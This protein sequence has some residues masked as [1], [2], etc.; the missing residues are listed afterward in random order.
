[1][2][3]SVVENR[4]PFLVYAGGYVAHVRRGR[5]QPYQLQ[6]NETPICGNLPN[7]RKTF[8][9]K[10]RYDLPVCRTCENLINKYRKEN[11]C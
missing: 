5:F 10:H 4:L 11:T 8:I 2:E 9:Q 7:G 1:M 3:S 6:L